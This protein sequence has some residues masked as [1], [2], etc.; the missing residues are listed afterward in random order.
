MSAS[1]VNIS[2]S[3]FHATSS[4]LRSP[5]ASSVHFFP[6]GSERRMWPAGSFTSPSNICGSHGHG[7]SRSSRKFLNGESGAALGVTATLFPCTT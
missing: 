1:N 3:S 7:M 4:G 6:L 2:P 5:P